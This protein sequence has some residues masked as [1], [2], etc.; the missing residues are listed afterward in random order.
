MTANVGT[1]RVLNGVSR[2]SWNT[3]N[4]IILVNEQVF[5]FNDSGTRGLM[6]LSVFSAGIPSLCSG[7]RMT[8]KKSDCL[9]GGEGVVIPGWAELLFKLFR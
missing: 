2:N 1:Y 7:F 5:F 3:N 9:G 4:Q 6:A 8:Q